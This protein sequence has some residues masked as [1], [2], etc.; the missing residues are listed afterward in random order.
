MANW[1]KMAEA[2][3]RAMNR[4]G[5]TEKGRELVQN[6]NTW[7]HRHG[8]VQ[9]Y[10]DDTPAQKGMKEGWHR[11]EDDYYGAKD[12]AGERG[13]DPNDP[14]V[15]EQMADELIDRDTDAG[16]IRNRQKEWDN[17]FKSAKERVKRGYGDSYPADMANEGADAF[18]NQLWDVID[19]LKAQGRSVEDILGA[20]KSMGQK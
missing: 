5:A 19:D 4:P 12:L 2:F 11:G 20:L 7:K 1:K 8:D 13:L 16:L 9:I 15:R 3:G 6:S 14:K 10:G 17:A 18:E